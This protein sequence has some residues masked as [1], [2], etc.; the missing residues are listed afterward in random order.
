MTEA[1]KE[2]NTSKQFNW[3]YD[4][5]NYNVPEGSYSTNPYDGAI[6]VKEMKQMVQALHGSGINVIMDVVYNHVYDAGQFGF[7]MIVPNYFSRTNPDGSYSNGSG[8]GNDTASERAMVRKYIVDSVK[9]WADEYHID[10]FR[11]DLVG[12]LDAQTINQIVE[13]VHKTHPYVIFYGEGWTMN[14]AVEPGNTVMATQQNAYATPKFAY[15]SDTLRD[16]LKGKNDE[17]SWGYVQNTSD[18]DPEGTLMECFL[19]NTGWIQ[20][21][22]QVINYASCHDNYTLMDKIN[23]TKK[24]SSMADRIKMNNLAA[25]IYMTAEGIPLIHAG[26][27]LLRTKVDKNGHIIHNSYNSPDYINSLK[28][29]DLSSKD[30]QNVRDYYKGLIEFRKN[31]AVL[32]LTTKADV[33]KYVSATWIDENVV[34]FSFAGKDK[35]AS[36]VSD[37]VVIIFNPN[38]SAKTFNMYEAGVASGTWKICVNDTK[39]GTDS[40]GTVTDGKVTV[41]AISALILVK[42]ETVDKNSVYVKNAVSDNDYDD[43]TDK[44]SSGNDDKPSGGND[45]QPSGGNDDEPSGGN[46]DKPSDDEEDKPLDEDE[47]VKPE[48]VVI[49]DA[50]IEDD[51]EAVDILPITDEDKEAIENGEEISISLDVKD[52]TGNVP[53]SDI[54]KFAAAL[55]DNRIGSYVDIS[56][57][58]QVGSKDKEFVAAMNG[59][60]SIKVTVPVGLRPG[61]GVERTF[62]V[63]GLSDGTVTEYE[64]VYNATDNTL[65]FDTD[66]SCIY[67]IAYRDADNGEKEKEKSFPWAIPVVIIIAGG[68][69]A[70]FVVYKKKKNTTSTGE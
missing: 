70:G 50:E 52:V 31:H 4:P 27:E 57:W 63:F 44:P 11:F 20:N 67:A 36:E 19:A 56:I 68:A 66:K 3:G 24:S 8:C 61:S 53:Q 62:T 51:K 34:M 12:L 7:N 26:E 5:V 1:Q 42:G 16:F 39:A 69:A 58:K 18:G 35:V 64:V 30:Y 28:W 59:K 9:Y 13:E 15:F 38:P 60:I 65:T 55:G 33:K 54:S 29:G 45:E 43:E 46:D 22:T 37:G 23:A 25:A 14:T 2:A 48:D 21:P 6:R 10:G 41:P 17:V 40:L 49:E 47:T 32:R